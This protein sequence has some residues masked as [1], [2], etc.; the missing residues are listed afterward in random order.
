MVNITFLNVSI[1]K[2]V[3]NET[4]QVLN[5]TREGPVTISNAPEVPMWLQHALLAIYFALLALAILLMMHYIYYAR[6]ARPASGDPPDPPSDVPLSIIIPVKNEATETVV[7]AVR[8]L[9]QLRCPN[10]EVVVVSDDPPEKA[11]EL[12]KALAGLPARVLR[13]PNPTGYKGAALNWAVEHARGEILLFLDVDSVP[14]PDLC[15]RARA[16]GEREI[17]FL[18]WDGYAAVKTP[19]AA[20]Q[21][22]LYKYL[23][24]YVAILGRYNTGHPV[25]ALGS[26]IAV[27][28]RFLREVGGFC[29]CTADD[30]DISMKAYLSGGRVVYL[31]GPPVYVE[32]PAGYGAFKRQYAR[33]TYNSAYLLAQYARQILKL[34]MP[35]AHRLSVFLNVAT[36][37]LMILTTFATMVATVAMSYMGILLPPFHILA[38]QGGLL[39]L[40]LAQTFYVYKLAKPDGHGFAEVA[41]MLAKSAALLLALSPYLTFYV[42]LGLLRRRIRWYVT[43]KGLAVLKSGALGPYEVATTSALAALLALSF[44][45]ANWLF[46]TNAATLLLV[47]LYVYLRVA[48]AAKPS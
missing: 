30:Y 24:Y 2:N 12:E 9:A 11:A 16:V 17:A 3:I 27:R 13:R 1:P 6:H 32:V 18:G 36:H 15:A 20:L 28:K 5:R 7:N 23:L 41:S 42:L 25:F 21:L 22:F 43:P 47:F 8:R 33:W 14:P 44:Y 29:N 40:A 26:G 31:P 39:A 46:I 48:A 45:T 10:A 4:L 34:K 37:P 19:I 35:L 38:M